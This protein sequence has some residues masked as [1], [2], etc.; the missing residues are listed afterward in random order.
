MVKYAQT[1][2]PVDEPISLLEAKAQLRV[3]G[4]DDDALI[5][6]LIETVREKFEDSTAR[7]LSVRDFTAYWDAWP[8]DNTLSLPLYPVLDVSSIKYLDDDGVEQTIST[9]DYTV[10][11]VGQSPRIM[12]NSDA[13]TPDVGN[14]PNSVYVRF[15]AGAYT[16]P[17]SAKHS[18]LLWLTMLYERREDM[19]LQGTDM[20]TR[21]AQWL[22]FNHRKDLI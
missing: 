19:N 20:G 18:M 10:D 3:D 2:T 17:P 16:I 6:D 15:T 11:K 13:D 9:S 14:Y 5:G 22:S 7:V 12:L 1:T 21:S 8:E 4:S